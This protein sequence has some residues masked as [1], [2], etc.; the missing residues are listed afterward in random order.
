MISRDRGTTFA[1]GANR[2]A[3]QALQIADR[4]PLLRN[5]GEALEKV[6]T[7]HH[8]DLKRVFTPPEEEDQSTAALDQQALT[9]LKALSQAEQL[10]QARRAQREAVAHARSGIVCTGVE[11]CF[12][13]S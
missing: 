6:L 9:R 4:G 11:W 8:A 2:G 12:N 3:P 10:R 13:R 7:R 5:L 1:D